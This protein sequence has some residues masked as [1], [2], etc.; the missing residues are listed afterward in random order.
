MSFQL[1]MFAVTQPLAS[2]VAPILEGIVWTSD[3]CV[4]PSSGAHR[5][6]KPL[7]W[8][9]LSFHIEYALWGEEQRITGLRR[10]HR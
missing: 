6:V 2:S 8:E 7:S 3:I 1:D 9:T 4:L 10:E 5:Q